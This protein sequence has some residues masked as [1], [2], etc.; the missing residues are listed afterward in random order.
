M[1]IEHNI[2][3]YE[4]MKKLAMEELDR[5]DK[6]L[7]EEV[8]RAKRKIEELQREKKVVKQIYDYA[9]TLLGVNSVVE[10]KE[11]ALD[12]IENRALEPGA[13]ER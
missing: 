9:C 7:N 13:I 12:N 10:I 1:T 5:L 6:E 8:I 2:T 3:S 11:Y 4:T